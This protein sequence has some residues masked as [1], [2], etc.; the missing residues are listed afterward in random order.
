MAGGR[1]SRVLIASLVAA[2]LAL[3]AVIGIWTTAPAIETDLETSAGAALAAAGISGVTPEADGRIIT[4]YGP[5]REPAA[6]DVA[7]NTV[8]EVFG[9]RSVLDAFGAAAPGAVTAGYRLTATWTGA[10]LTLSGAMPS[11]DA[12][13]SLV[14]HG[15]DVFPGRKIVDN[16][17]VAPNPPAEKWTDAAKGGLK[18]MQPLSNAILTIEGT[19]VTLTGAAPSEEAKSRA[20]DLLAG[21][22]EP[23]TMLADID[24]STVEAPVAL[25]TY[26]LAAA[27]D[28]SRLALSGSLPSDAA[29]A[30]IRAA[31]NRD[32]LTIDDKTGLNTAAPDGAFTDAAIVALSALTRA[33]SGTMTLEGR[34]LTLDSIAKDA[35]TQSAIAQSLNDLPAAYTWTAAIGIAGAGPAAAQSSATESPARTCQAAISDALAAN[36][37]VFASAS[38]EL[39]DSAEPL[40]TQIAEAAATCPDARLEIAGHT[41]SSGNAARN[42]TLSED[43][44]SAV[45]AALI[46]KGVDAARLS[47]T[48]YGAARP[49]AANDNDADKARNRRIEVIVRP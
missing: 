36:P 13:E 38:S 47:A 33:V 18:A 1:D 23:F 15:R 20:N 6:R 5:A 45:E 24:I 10:D 4:L 9:V 46:V 12:R 48:G 40:V 35:A 26:S 31:L 19:S 43:R 42:V 16:L 2:A 49:I 39:P 27:F 17:T 25:A 14:A 7:I 8:A 34:G 22:P 30:A 41:D 32:G 29:R 11:L 28:G 21:L 3:L 44:A 37:I